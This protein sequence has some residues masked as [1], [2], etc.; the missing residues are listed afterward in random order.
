MKKGVTKKAATK[1][2]LPKKSTVKKGAKNEKQK[3]GV[4]LRPKANEYQQE[5]TAF[6]S[7][8]DP[9]NVRLDS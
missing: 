2:A 7:I 3:S 5:R 6:V 1:K 4:M 8:N 9:L